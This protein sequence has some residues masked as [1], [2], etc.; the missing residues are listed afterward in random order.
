VPQAEKFG[1]AT[2]CDVESVGNARTSVKRTTDDFI[3]ILLPRV[4]ARL[5]NEPPT[6]FPFDD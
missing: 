1:A 3:S 6:E 4:I 2:G 5:A